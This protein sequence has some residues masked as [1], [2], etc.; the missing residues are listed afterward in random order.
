MLTENGQ[1]PAPLVY[2]NLVLHNH[3]P[4][5]NFENVFEQAYV[6]SYRPFLDLF[7]PCDGLKISLHTSG[8][9]ME[10][11]DARHPEYVDRLA[12]LVAAGRI[13]IIGGGFHEPILTMLPA[14][15]RVGQIARYS[16]WLRRRLG[17]D[18]EGAWIAERVWETCLVSDL[19]AA[20]IRYTVL[21]DFH[22]RCAGLVEEELDGWFLTEDQGRTLAVFPGSERLR[23]LIPFRDP[24]ET[25]DL[26][27]AVGQRRPGSVLVFGDD[28]EKFGTWPETKKHV[29]ED[30]W[31]KRFFD[32][33]V[34]N[35]DWLKTAT[36]A[37]TMATTASRGKVWLPD[38]SYREMTEWALPVERQAVLQR[39]T[40]ELEHDPRWAGLKTFVRGGYWR[41]FKRKYPETDEL[42]TR[43][44]AVSRLVDD[45]GPGGVDPSIVEQARML[46]YR[47]QCNCS[48]WHGAFG[49]VYLPHLRNAAYGNLIQA[50]VMIERQTHPEPEWI[51]ATAEDFNFDGAREVRLAN[52]QLVT[53][54]APAAGGQIYGLD[55]R[56]AAHNLLAT[57]QR[58]PEAYHQKIVDRERQHADGAASIHDRVILKRDD[59]DQFLQS[60][61][62]LRKSLV[63]QFWDETAIGD[64]IASGRAA[65]QG[66]FADGPWEA[67]IRRH[68]ERIQVLLVRDG[69]ASG[70]PIRISKG[71]TMFP[72]NS[73]LEIGYLLEHLP[74]S[75]RL[76]FGIEFNFAGLPDGQDDRYFTSGP[77]RKRL[78]Q[79][80]ESQD[81]ADIRDIGLHDEWLGI[82]AGLESSRP[83]G[84]WAFP[85]RT[86]S[87]SEAGFELV[88]QSVVVQPHWIVHPDEQG[89]WMVKLNLDLECKEGK[90]E[91][92]ADC[93]DFRRL[94]AAETR[95]IAGRA[96]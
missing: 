73:R 16:H 17:A 30:G 27:R 4:V 52:D 68:P 19:A 96:V 87:Q 78:G 11:L 79:L 20:G 83:T 53:W 61:H 72:G 84:F 42:Y 80:G 76:H 1:S 91:R 88:H 21:D 43:M 64:D 54:I 44:M 50:E 90:R 60:D 34:R 31:L 56:P 32:A 10:W 82:H 95:E 45:A 33:L 70:L 51:E 3:Q 86:V 85:V 23:Y 49:G 94:V 25:V 65:E 81:L 92:P 93:T 47:G 55:L 5:G 75:S 12:A 13:E 8:C 62:R 14:R 66:D 48:Y 41:N 74:P 89:R 28:G 67:T 24:E 77:D 63:D 37:E 58:R 18:V 7:E 69:M 15:D 6:D 2:L 59:L 36:L 29:Y 35:Q 40:H 46:L 38:A 22:F 39:L 71:V 26:C 57:M 9:L